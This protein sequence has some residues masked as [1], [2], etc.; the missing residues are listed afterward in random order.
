MDTGAA[1]GRRGPFIER[2]AGFPLPGGNALL[3]DLPFL[4]EVQDF[5][6]ERG[7]VYLICEFFE[8]WSSISYSTMKSATALR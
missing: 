1:V 8:Q 4:P 6:L 3:K 2:E 7:I 5:E